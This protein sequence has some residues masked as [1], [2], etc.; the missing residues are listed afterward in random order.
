MMLLLAGGER[1]RERERDEREGGGGGGGGGS[2]GSISAFM[3]F[4]A[5]S[6]FLGLPAY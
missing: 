2:V 1:E 4:K 5:D 6:H 3:L